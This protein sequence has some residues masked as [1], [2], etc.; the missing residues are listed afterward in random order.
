MQWVL[1][2]EVPVHVKP[3]V[4]CYGRGHCA[5][6]HLDGVKQEEKLLL[7]S[8][9]CLEFSGALEVLGDLPWPSVVPWFWD[10][11]LSPSRHFPPCSLEHFYSQAA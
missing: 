5:I 9:C 7:T 8:S 1:G 3:V 4:L 11:L 2:R 10:H 6:C